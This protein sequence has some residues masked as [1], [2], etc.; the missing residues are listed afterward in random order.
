VSNEP[1]MLVLAYVDLRWGGKN[2]ANDATFGVKHVRDTGGN[3]THET[4]V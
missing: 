4:C 3:V 2:P 1:F